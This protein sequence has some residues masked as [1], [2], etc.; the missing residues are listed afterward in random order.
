[1]SGDTEVELKFDARVDDSLPDLSGVCAAV[2]VP[3]EVR[4]QATYFDT[5]DLRLARRRLSLRRRTGGDDAGWHLKVPVAADERIEMR[6]PLGKATTAVPQ[7]LQDEIRAIVRDR[8]LAPVAVLNTTRVE[9]RLLNKQGEGVAIVA[10]DTVHAEKLV[11]EPATTAWREVEVELLT[12]DRGVL[13]VLAH[14]LRDAGLRRSEAASKLARALGEAT[15]GQTDFRAAGKEHQDQTAG[16]VAWRHLDDQVGELLAR[17]RAARRDEADGVHKMRV[18]TRRLR[19]AMAT[20]RPILQRTQTDPIRDELKWLGQILGRARDAEVQRDRL[21]ELTDELPRELVLGPVRRRIKLEMR[22]RHRTAH[23]AL[24]QQLTSPRYWRL[25]DSLENLLTHPA[26][27]ARAENDAGERLPKL[28]RKAARRVDQTAQVAG[29]ASG[30]AHDHALHE[31][32]K[33]A[34]RARYAA[35]PATAVIGKP[36]K[37]LAKRMEAVQDV[38]GEHQDS[39]TARRLLRELTAAAHGQ[40]ESTFTFGLMYREELARG[41]SAREVSYPMLR[42]AQDAARDWPG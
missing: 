42:K 29:G 3:A 37:R 17:D 18:A 23:A 10:D 15:V 13:D 35:E 32:R 14:R 2:S 24:V 40:R 26:F 7:S 38:L 1:M 4:L 41:M 19:S 21:L 28:V 5:D 27:T 9:H 36:A 25:L 22:A 34:K 33:A 39:V 20:F 6:R 11:G 31:V 12:G 16:D 8:P 30:E